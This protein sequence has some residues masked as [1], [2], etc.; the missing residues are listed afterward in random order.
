MPNAMQAWRGCQLPDFLCLDK[1]IEGHFFYKLAILLVS[2]YKS[3]TLYTHMKVKLQIEKC[4]VSNMKVSRTF[5]GC[6]AF[7]YN[8]NQAIPRWHCKNCIIFGGLRD[9]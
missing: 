4:K 2:F 3:Y 7:C 5:K 1:V 9:F 6:K 8:A